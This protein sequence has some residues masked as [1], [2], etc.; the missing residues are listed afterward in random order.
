MRQAGWRLTVLMV[1]VSAGAFSARGA[2][3]QSFTGAHGTGNIAVATV[4]EGRDGG[5]ADLAAG[6]A[7]RLGGSVSA[8]EIVTRM[9]EMN[10]ERLAALEHYESERTYRL[11]YT[12]TGGAH[13]A[14]LRVRAEYLGP[15]QRSLTVISESG[16]KFLCDKVLRKLVESEQEAAA[17]SNRMQTTLGP[18][19]Y[20]AELLGEELVSTPAGPL[21]AWVLRVTPKVDNKFTYRGRVWVS[22]D[23]YAVVRIEGEPG[24]NPSWWIDRASFESSYARHGDVWLPARNVSSSSVRIGGQA[25][26]TIDYGTY[27]VVSAR[28]LRPVAEMV[29]SSSH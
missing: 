28:A 10:E 18:Q 6:D 26:L 19:N 14:E 27:P 3:A 17:Q 23:D 12:G 9:L 2:Q 11:E 25:T 20:D 29:A 15:S 21:R 5:T 4:D 24:R 22:Q 7:G 1:I 16:S 13:V 8:T